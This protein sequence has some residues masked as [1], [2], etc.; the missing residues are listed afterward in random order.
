VQC[1]G[2]FRLG[3]GGQV[4]GFIHCIHHALA[5]NTKLMAFLCQPDR[6]GNALKQSHVEPRFES[7]DEFAH[8]R[9]R[10]QQAPSGSRKT[11]FRD[12]AKED[13]HFSK[14]VHAGFFLL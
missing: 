1:A 2:D 11:A 5:G 6:A 14:L 3:R 8:G 9:R 12:N 13:R 7:P 4:F 10:H